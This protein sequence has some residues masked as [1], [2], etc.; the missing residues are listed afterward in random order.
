MDNRDR[1]AAGGPNG[2]NVR[3]EALQKDLENL[4]TVIGKVKSAIEAVSQQPPVQRLL[5]LS[6]AFVP[7]PP[8]KAWSVDSFGVA[9]RPSSEP[10]VKGLLALSPPDGVKLLKFRAIGKNTGSGSLRISLFRAPVAD[11]SVTELLARIPGEGAYD[12]Q[13][14]IEAGKDRVDMT[15]F[16]YFVT[17]DLSNA[18][19][20]DTV[21]VISVQ[22]SYLID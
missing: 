20:G 2:F 5:S 6:P 18:S 12:D 16:R 9:V 4:S 21:T 14:S 11:G 3:F 22:L 17:A 8:S 15:S 10:S 13:R 7:M 1:V 19:T